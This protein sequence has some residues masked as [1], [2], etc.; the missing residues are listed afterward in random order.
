MIYDKTTGQRIVR[1]K[2]SGDIVYTRQTDSTVLKNQSVQKNLKKR[3]LMTAGIL[4]KHKGT[5]AELAGVKGG[6]LNE[7]GQNEDF[8]DREEGEV[9]LGDLDGS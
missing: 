6:N 8:W 3:R 5:R 7:V 9:Y 4:N 1:S 2:H